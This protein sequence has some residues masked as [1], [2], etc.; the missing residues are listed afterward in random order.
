MSIYFLE[1][2]SKERAFYEEKLRSV[3]IPL[4]F[5]RSV[6]EIKPDAQIVSTFLFPNLKKEFFEANP[7]LRLIAARRGGAERIDLEMCKQKGIIVSRVPTYGEY[8]VAEHTMAL[9][10]TLSRRL[11]EAM[12]AGRERQFSYQDLRGFN[13]NGKTLG[14]IGA[15][16]IGL[17]TLRIAQAFGMHTIAYDTLENPD[18]A[19]ML[20]FQYKTLEELFAQS[21]IISL[22]TPLTEQTF[23]MMN[24][25]TFAKCKKGVYIINTARGSLIDTTAL[26][27]ALD[28]GQVAGAGLDVLEEESILRQETAKIIGA[29]I[30]SK[31]KTVTPKSVKKSVGRLAS[32]N[33]IDTPQRLKELDG[34][35]RHKALL[36]RPNVII[37][38]HTGFNSDEAAE[39]IQ[40]TTVENI[41]AFLRGEPINLI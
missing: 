38:P 3:G 20:G 18:W 1:T 31:L 33:F 17:H 30:V 34:L 19:Q 9:I 36:A 26:L 24:A 22:H 12:I 5:V 28:S 10:L 11:R 21:D 23:H 14:V 27:D 16:R 15:G 29:Q 2:E 8:T 13:L 41:L 39:L 40:K 7:K 6:A 25:S 32:P 37:T 4:R 35:M